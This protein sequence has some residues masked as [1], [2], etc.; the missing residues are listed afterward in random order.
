MN[1]IQP[2]FTALA[3]AI[4]T[5]TLVACNSV[6]SEDEQSAS[7]QVNPV[8]IA[9]QEAPAVEELFVT[10]SR[11]ATSMDMAASVAMARAYR[12]ELFVRQQANRENYA[13]LVDN[14]I[15]RTAQEPVS[16][17]SID[18][19]TGAYSNVRRFINHGQL[20]PADAVRT[21][22]LMN[23]FSYDYPAA[24]R[25]EEPFSIY[26][27]IAPSPW[28]E[29]RHLVHIGIEAVDPDEEASPAR[30]LVFLVDV[31][32]SMNSPDKLDLLKTSLKLLTRRL[33]ERDSIAIVVYAGASGVVLEPTAGDETHKITAALDRLSAGGGTNGESGIR[34]AYSLAQQQFVEG[35]INRV[36]L[37]TD[38]DFNVGI[39]DVDKLKELI[40]EKRK[41]GIS[42]TTLGF[43]TGNYNDHLMEQLADAGNGNYAYIDTINEA[44]KVLVDELSSTL[45]TVASDVKIQIEF[46]PAVVSEYRLLGYENRVL[47]NQDFNNDKVDAGE[48]GAG[49]TVTALYE[50]S[51]SGGEA[52]SVDPLRYGPAPGVEVEN[53]AL[54]GELAFLK[55]RYKEPDGGSSRLVQRP[56]LTAD[57]RETMASASE[58]YRFAAAV[59]G[60]AQ[61]LRDNSALGAFTYDDVLALAAA[62]RG[63]DAF[64][65]RSEFINLVKTAQV[66]TQN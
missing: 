42:L 22:E 5:A 55:L 35:G 49:H 26:T 52:Q 11:V 6:D 40:E 63:Q 21:E 28:Y 62:A 44:R 39:A 20:P 59:A 2:V 56:L 53:P 58:D 60:F 38:G 50:I 37:A 19:D 15:I 25:G 57:I 34:L 48:I 66:L 51:L 36:L 30:N 41:S 46:N 18:V 3:I 16:T 23:Y 9:R 17:F 33:D 29:G 4:S 27:E 1:R 31:S 7:D 32:G 65:Y 47:A 12:P 54:A 64:G 8:S 61:L 14:R 13:E 10:G 45:R 24:D 43:G